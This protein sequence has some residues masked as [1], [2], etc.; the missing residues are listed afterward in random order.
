MAVALLILAAAARALLWAQIDDG[1]L[2]RIARQYLE[3]LS[4]WC[5]IAA[6]TD[7]LAGGAAGD[8]GLLSLALPVAIGAAAVLLRSRGE[9]NEPAGAEP[10]QPPAAP[11]AA[12]A[13]AAPAPAP[14][15][16]LWSVPADGDATRRGS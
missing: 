4:T 5:L 7:A 9:A 12:A 15:G 2:E 16:S 1:R 13:A 8:A 3:P 11:A 6:A 14:A 10:E